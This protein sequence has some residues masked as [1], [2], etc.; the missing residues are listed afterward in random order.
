M[1]PSGQ[2]GESPTGARADGERLRPPSA[3]VSGSGWPSDGRAEETPSGR[4]EEMP[5]AKRRRVG[6]A[7]SDGPSASASRRARSPSPAAARTVGSDGPGHSSASGRRRAKSPSPAAARMPRRR[8]SAA[9]VADSA[10]ESSAAE[11]QE[12]RQ[13]LAL[14]DEAHAAP[15]AGR[16]AAQAAAEEEVERIMAAPRPAQVLRGDSVPEKRQDFRRIV[17]LLHPDKGLV[18]GPRANLALRRTIAAHGSLGQSG[19]AGR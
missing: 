1:P 12:L 9:P 17:R 14:E 3:P 2:A 11:L 4:A 19:S 10:P 18:S 13:I 7:A 8:T 5:S 16:A 15:L 6:S